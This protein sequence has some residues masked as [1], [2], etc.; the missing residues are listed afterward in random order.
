MRAW[1]HNAAFLTRFRDITLAASSLQVL[2]PEQFVAAGDYLVHA[3]P[4]WSWYAGSKQARL[5]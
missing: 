4:T 3:C 5:G 2:T 1:H